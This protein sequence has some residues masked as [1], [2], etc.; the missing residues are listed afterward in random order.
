MVYKIYSTKSCPK[1]EQL[2]AALVKAGIAFENI[3]MSTPEA[4]TELRINGVF[5]L[6][7]PVLQEED[8]FYTVE[9]LFSGDNLRDLAGILKG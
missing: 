6:S 1:C 9:D 3:D 4:L 2:K 5:T 7:A 8:N